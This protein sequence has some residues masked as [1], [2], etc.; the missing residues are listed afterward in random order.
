M[1]AQ[2]RDLVHSTQPKE[3]PYVKKSLKTKHAIMFRLSNKV[4]Q[5]NFNDKTQLILCPDKRKVSY[6]NKKGE[7]Q[8]HSLSTVYDTTNEELR[9]RMLYTKSI[10][11]HLIN[12]TGAGAG[13]ETG[14]AEK[15]AEPVK[16]VKSPATSVE[17]K[18]IF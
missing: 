18:M 1:K 17:R 4:V 13:G 15:K 16:V 5:V 8:S 2:K 9:K 11:T 3:M 6:L 12:N 10:L 7:L 14:A